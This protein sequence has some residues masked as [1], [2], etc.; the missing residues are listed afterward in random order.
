M[1][2]Y[3][4]L[5][6]MCF[7]SYSYGTIFSP[8]SIREGRCHRKLATTQEDTSSNVATRDHR[9]SIISGTC[10]DNNK[11]KRRKNV[12]ILVELN[13]EYFLNCLNMMLL[14]PLVIKIKLRALT[15]TLSIRPAQCED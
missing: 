5:P 8:V 1:C 2:T 14:L 7:C 6:Q 13:I 11:K 4:L 12:L 9:M 10:S 3:I 15:L